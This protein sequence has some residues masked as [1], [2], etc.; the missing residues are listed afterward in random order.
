M[1]IA[2][3]SMAYGISPKEKVQSLMQDF[4]NEHRHTYQPDLNGDSGFDL[5]TE[6]DPDITPDKN[7]LA[8]VAK[9]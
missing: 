1:C 7:F 5:V 6:D 2:K 4:F 8:K 9:T 3:Y